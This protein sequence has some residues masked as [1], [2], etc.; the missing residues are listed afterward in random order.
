MRQKTEDERKLAAL[1]AL[2][3]NFGKE[4]SESLLGI[5]LNLLSHYS[6]DAVDAGVSRVI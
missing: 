5:W 3:A 2:A 6:A 4:F 1:M